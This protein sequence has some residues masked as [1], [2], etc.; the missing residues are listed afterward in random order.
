MIYIF[1][2][3]EYKFETKIYIYEYII[4]HYLNIIRILSC[5]VINYHYKV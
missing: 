1:I 2:N 4:L 3:S 5:I